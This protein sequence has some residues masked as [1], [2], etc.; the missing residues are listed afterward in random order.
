M[1]KIRR[2]K[3]VDLLRMT[4]FGKSV[5]VKGW[6]RTKRGNK[7]VNFIALNDGSCIHNLQIV[8]DVPEFPE[9]LLKKITTGAAISVTGELMESQGSGQKVEVQ[10]KDIEVLGVADP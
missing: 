6:V 8:V 4:E 2:I 3:V 1:E 10:A 7:H 5:N 9:E